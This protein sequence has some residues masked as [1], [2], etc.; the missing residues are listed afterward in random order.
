VHARFDML[1]QEADRAGF[2]LFHG[3]L[4]DLGISSDQ[5]DD[6][7]RGLS[8]AVDGPLDMRMDPTAGP[9]AAD[10]VN[11]MAESDLADLIFRL[12]E[13]PRSRRIARAVFRSRPVHTTRELASIVAAA[14]GYR[15]GRTH[16]A[17]R[18]FQAL[19]M[20]VN[21]ELEVLE[22]ALP[23]AVDRLASAGR[24]AVISFHSLEDRL[25]KQTFR[26]LAADCICPPGVPEC[27]CGHVA[28]LEVITRRPITPTPEEVARNPRARSAKLRVAAR[29]EEARAA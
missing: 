23:Q 5:L 1:A 2:D 6:P 17:T 13:E 24:I 10:L 11:T 19:R 12:G 8:F 7:D 9:T 15:G 20:A 27:R 16:P 22:R 26:R 21:E 14:S 3:V 25:V 4:L 28:S 29:L 18:T